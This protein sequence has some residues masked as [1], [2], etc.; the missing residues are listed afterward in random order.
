MKKFDIYR[1]LSFILKVG[2]L[3]WI[4]RYAVFLIYKK[5]LKKNPIIII[6]N[7]MFYCFLESPTSAEIYVTNADIDFGTENFIRKKITYPSNIVDVGG[8]IGYYGSILK[9][10]IDTIYIF[11][12]A[13]ENNILLKKNLE[14]IKKI[15]IENKFCSNEERTIEIKRKKHWSNLLNQNGPIKEKIE[16]IKLDNYFAKI[17]KKIDFIKIDVDGHDFEVL[18]GAE[19]LIIQNKP[20]L[21][22]ECGE[23]THEKFQYKTWKKFTNK[24][25]YK[26]NAFKSTKEFIQIESD[27]DIRE[28]K[29]LL[30]IPNDL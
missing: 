20:L 7:N 27:D 5:F 26:I 10:K 16:I 21:A 2:L 28:A 25:N 11:E 19:N 4:Y 14:G 23:E 12:P 22:I 6:N 15:I 29:M 18:L 24:I 17:N 8:H 30:L 13:K 1:K 3:K 9:D